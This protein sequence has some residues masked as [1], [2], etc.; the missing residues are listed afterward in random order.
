MTENRKL[1]LHA[2]NQIGIVVNDVD[3]TMET[4]WKQFGIGPWRIYHL[5]PG[6][7]DMTYYGEP[8]SFSL[9]VAVARIG[10]LSIELLQPLSGPTPLK[11]FL[12]KH[13]EGMQHVG[14]VVDNLDEAT[15]KMKHQGYRVIMSARGLGTKGDGG[16]AY[17]NT[18][19]DLGTLV[20]FIEMPKEMQPP[21]TVYPNPIE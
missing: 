8:C 11:D 19:Q 13:G 17:F 20:E 7:K 12:E 4:Y 18:D 3:K 16:S 2:I 21:Q 1:A 10:T 5:G 6:M 14:I 15:E 9:K